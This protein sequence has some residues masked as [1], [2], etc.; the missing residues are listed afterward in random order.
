MERRDPVNCYQVHID[1]LQLGETQGWENGLNSLV[2]MCRL[3]WLARLSSQASEKQEPKSGGAQSGRGLSFLPPNPS[4]ATSPQEL[5]LPQPEGRSE[6]RVAKT[7]ELGEASGMC[8][9]L[10]SGHTRG[11]WGLG[12]CLFE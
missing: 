4:L 12:G 2:V 10:A 3:L 6:P 9:G 8:R 5:L 11:A 7:Q 1:A